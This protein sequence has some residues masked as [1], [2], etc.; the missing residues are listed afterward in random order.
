MALGKVRRYRRSRPND[1]ILKDSESWRYPIHERDGGSGRAKGEFQG[2]EISVGDVGGEVLCG[3]HATPAAGGQ[4]GD[5]CPRPETDA[6]DPSRWP[7]QVTD[8]VPV[9]LSLPHGLL[10]RR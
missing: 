7:T 8:A 3:V 9:P 2:V 6:G 4:T 1:L 10:T 5:R